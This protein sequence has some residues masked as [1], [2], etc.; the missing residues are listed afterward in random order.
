MKKAKLSMRFSTRNNRYSDIDKLNIVK[1]E[2]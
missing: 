1:Y 2:S